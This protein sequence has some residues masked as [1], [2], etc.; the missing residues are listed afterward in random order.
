MRSPKG[1]M[2]LFSRRPNRGDGGRLGGGSPCCGVGLQLPD[3]GILQLQRQPFLCLIKRYD[4]EGIWCALIRWR[5]NRS[6]RILGTE[7][8]DGI[9]LINA[10]C[11]RTV[12]SCPATSFSLY[13]RSV[14]LQIEECQFQ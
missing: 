4:P 10:G 2:T 13:Q 11:G 8:N 14:V 9:P 6:I 12:Q 7:P 5:P 3:P 1:T